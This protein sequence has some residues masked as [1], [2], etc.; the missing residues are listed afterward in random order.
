MRG[1]HTDP[2]L[3]R[4]GKSFPTLEALEDRTCP[5]SISLNWHTLTITGDNT[6]NLVNVLDG[7]HGNVTASVRDANGRVTTR[8]VTGVTS[9]AI[10]TGG[11]NDTVNYALTAPLTTSESLGINLGNGNNQANLNYSRGVTAPHLTVRVLGGTGDDR[12]SA[13]LG[14]VKNTTVDFRT[15]L[16]AGNDQIFE[17]LT[18][19]LT[20]YARVY[21]QNVDGTGYDGTNFQAVSNIASTASLQVDSLGGTNPDTFH[22]NYSGQLNGRLTIHT[23]GGPKFSWIESDINIAYG[24]TGALDARLLGGLDSDLLILRVK[25]YS[26]HLRYLSAVMDGGGG[27]NVGIATPNVRVLRTSLN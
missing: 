6:A 7:G 12:L 17:R 22:V 27:H 15:N 3:G 8:R 10:N 20:G 9:I 19:A 11:G 25:D 24:S 16:G 4:A 18:G 26:H 13:T 2:N 1:R 14:P 21:F 23:T 5:S